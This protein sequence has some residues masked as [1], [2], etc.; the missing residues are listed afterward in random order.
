MSFNSSINQ[1][2]DKDDHSSNDLST[3]DDEKKKSKKV[4][5]EGHVYDLEDGQLISYIEIYIPIWKKYIKIDSCDLFKYLFGNT[6]F[7]I[8]T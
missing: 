2:R 1:F 4:V 3:H 5:F 7:I 6:I 8:F